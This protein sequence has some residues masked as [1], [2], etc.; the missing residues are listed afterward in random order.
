[1]TKSQ[2]GKIIRRVQKVAD[3]KNQKINASEVSRVASLT[4]DEAIKV[5]Q[6]A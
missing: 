2:R 3:T 4:L 1:M 5:L 6:R